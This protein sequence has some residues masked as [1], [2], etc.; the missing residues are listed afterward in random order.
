MSGA[1]VTRDPEEPELRLDSESH[2]PAPWSP[3]RRLAA[4]VGNRSFAR[5]ITGQSAGPGLL[6]DPKTEAKPPAQMPPAADV[7][8]YRVGG[9][10]YTE[11]QYAVA[12]GQVA[13]LWTEGNGI[14]AKQKQAIG[15]FCGKGG[16]G[17]DSEPDLLE[18]VFEAAVL[19][20]IG[21][22]TDGVGLAVGAAAE[23][24][25]GKLI[26]ALPK[27]IE[28]GAVESV[29]KKVLDTAVEKGKDKAKEAAKASVTK[30][31]TV[32]TPGGYRKLSTPLATFQA[33]LEDAADSGCGEEKIRTLQT[34][35]DYQEVTPPEA[36][37]IAAAAIYDGL[38]ATLQAADELQW[39]ATSDGWF[40]MQMA[41]GRDTSA[42]ADVGRVLIDLNNTYPDAT[43]RVDAAYIYGQG[44]NETTLEPYDHRALGE[45]AMS[46]LVVMDNG[47]MGWGWV[48]CRWKMLLGPDNS[49]WGIKEFS[50]YG[51]LWLAAHAVGKEDLDFDDREFNYANVEKGASMVWDEVK[52]RTTKF[53]AAGATSGPDPW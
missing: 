25:I 50:R 38:K 16:A 43:V 37:W 8:H 26:S 23:A 6:R 36:K 40:N 15:R 27:A 7:P 53:K 1:E 9:N 2:D 46:K 48:P 29:M 12:V 44:V 41:S 3:Q 42:E 21:F 32:A 22:A 45:I 30:A 34:L 10:F 11:Q 28:K 47:K 14:V 13:D 52:D 24:G 18:G 49:V 5:A 17:A 35:L 20:I 4:A 51:E 19:A 33:A 31:P 39:N